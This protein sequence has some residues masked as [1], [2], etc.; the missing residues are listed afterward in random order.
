M[1]VPLLWIGES[2]MPVKK[3]RRSDLVMDSCINYYRSSRP[4]MP[5]EARKLFGQRDIYNFNRV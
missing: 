1:E 4:R 2:K 3:D 5:Y